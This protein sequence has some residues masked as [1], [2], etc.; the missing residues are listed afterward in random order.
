MAKKSKKTQ[1]RARRYRSARADGKVGSLESRIARDYGLPP[2]SVM[3]VG[4]DG[5]DKRSDAKVQSL[6]TEWDWP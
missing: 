1:G 5:K 2:G 3:I 6:L 4:P